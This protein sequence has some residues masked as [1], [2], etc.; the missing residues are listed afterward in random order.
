MIGNRGFCKQLKDQGINKK[1]RGIKSK[2]EAE[3]RQKEN[4]I[5]FISDESGLWTVSKE[6]FSQKVEKVKEVK[7]ESFDKDSFLAE[8]R[9]AI[10]LR[11]LSLGT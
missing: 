3:L 4:T 8:I 6:A 7:K 2:H 10:R 1:D 11:N 9:E 5:S